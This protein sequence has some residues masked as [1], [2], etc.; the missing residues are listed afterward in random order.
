M[1]DEEAKF[2]AVRGDYDALW[3]LYHSSIVK[4][5]MQWTGWEV[6][7]CIFFMG[8]DHPKGLGLW[9]WEGT[10]SIWHSCFGEGCDC[11]P[12]ATGKW[13]RARAVEVICC[14]SREKS[15]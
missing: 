2:L 8:D 5:E 7:D 10:I 14:T 3:I 15:V 4:E 6:E 1:Q 9:V 12:T 13:R 11:E